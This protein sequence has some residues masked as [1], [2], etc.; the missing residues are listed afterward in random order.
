MPKLRINNIYIYI[1]IYILC[2]ASSQDAEHVQ[3]VLGA[4]NRK[5][6]IRLEEP[7]F[8][9]LLYNKLK[10][11]QKLDLVWDYNTNTMS[12]HV[13]YENINMNF[14]DLIQNLN[15]SRNDVKSGEILLHKSTGLQLVFGNTFSVDSSK[16]GSIDESSLDDYNS[17]VS[18][19]MR[20]A[21]LT[22]S[23]EEKKPEISESPESPESP[24]SCSCFIT[25]LIIII[26]I[27][28][29]IFILSLIIKLL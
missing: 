3:F 12:F 1:F 13:F 18:S 10:Q 29:I 2:F 27:L 11:E 22:F 21:T 25:I 19:P 5:W 14:T 15:F 28:V 20:Q 23:I 26:L 6:N 4:G 8:R 7:G 9:Q 17:F 16:L 24:E